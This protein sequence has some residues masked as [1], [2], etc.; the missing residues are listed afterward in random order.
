VTAYPEKLSRQRLSSSPPVIKSHS[1]WRSSLRI[2]RPLAAF[3]RR[4]SSFSFVYSPW[5]MLAC[6]I[7]SRPSEVF[8]PV[9]APPCSLQ[10]PFFLFAGRWQPVPFRVLA[11]HVCPGQSAPKRH[12]IPILT[13]PFVSINHTPSIGYYYTMKSGYHRGRQNQVTRANLRS[14]STVVMC[15]SRKSCYDWKG[16]NANRR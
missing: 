14:H 13:L 7:R 11:P 12:S 15:L 4:F 2:C 10:R 16:L 8:A 1:I 3:P 6:E 5:R 9:L